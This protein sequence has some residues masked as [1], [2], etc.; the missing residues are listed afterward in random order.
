MQKLLGVQNVFFTINASTSY[1][2]LYFLRLVYLYIFLNNTLFLNHL[3]LKLMLK[4]KFL[5]RVL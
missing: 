4:F 5:N 2:V 3:Y 1:F